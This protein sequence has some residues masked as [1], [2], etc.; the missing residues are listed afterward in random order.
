[1]PP[2]WNKRRVGLQPV[3]AST[4]HH[5]ESDHRQG[6][7]PATNPTGTSGGASSSLPKTVTTMSVFSEAAAAETSPVSLQP[8]LNP[9]PAVEELL[10]APLLRAKAWTAWYMRPLTR[11][12][13]T[14]A[15]WRRINKANP[16]SRAVLR[17][18]RAAA[19]RRRR[20][21]QARRQ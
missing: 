5:T 6:G 15:A 11:T 14:P 13:P 10:A 7:Q 1:V 9:P 3:S 2:H 4:D 20:R 12:N 17:R 19:P 21:D 16:L 18:I 8:T